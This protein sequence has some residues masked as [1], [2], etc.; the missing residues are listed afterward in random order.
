MLKVGLRS[1]SEKKRVKFEHLVVILLNARI[2]LSK[3]NKKQA[4]I[5]YSAERVSRNATEWIFKRHLEV[6]S[7]VCLPKHKSLIE[8]I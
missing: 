5:K 1:R 6:N 7:K 8:S 2:Y 3:G 4:G